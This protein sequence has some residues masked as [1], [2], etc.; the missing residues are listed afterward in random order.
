MCR[1]ALYLGR[2]LSVSMLITQ[3]ANSIIHQSYQS[4]D[5]AEPLNGD[6]FGLAWYPSRSDDP[7]L[8]RSTT[9][10][11][12]NRNLR[13]LA[14]VTKTHCA[15]A[16]VRAASPGLPVTELNCHPFKHD[17]LTFM[18]NGDLGGFDA[19]RRRLLDSLSD[20]AFSMIEG[21]TDSEHLFAVFLDELRRRDAAEDETARLA[22]ALEATIVRAEALR[23]EVAPD[24]CSYLNLVVCDGE[25]AAVTRYATGK[26][27][28]TSLHFSKGR[29]YVCERGLCHMV[30]E[31]EAHTAVLIASEPLEDNEVWQTV[32]PHHMVVVT[33]A[34][35]V[36]TRPLA[37]A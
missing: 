17:R 2:E 25:R 1:F 8:F 19:L 10:A 3:P 27:R 28:P 31:G 15:L 23:R 7:A 12:S 35:E 24:A 13:E 34:L 29:V 36:T 6:G 26:T 33:P 4:H 21:T 32:E 14:R 11:W 18:H 20:E 37:L 9:P 30:G 5:R 16:H 22:G